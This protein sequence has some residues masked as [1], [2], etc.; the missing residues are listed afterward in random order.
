[1]VTVAEVAHVN[2]QRVVEHRAV[3]FL[4]GVQFLR[5][6]G[7]PLGMERSN[8]SQQFIGC[9]AIFPATVT[10]G[11]GAKRHAETVPL[12]VAVP[13]TGRDRDHI[14]QARQQRTGGH[15][16]L[17][18]ETV[19]L[20]RAL[21]LVGI[22]HVRLQ[23]VLHADDAVVTIEH[24]FVRFEVSVEAL[25]LRS[26]QLRLDS[27]NIPAHVIH[28]LL[29]QEGSLGG[30]SPGG[31]A[32]QRLEG[33][34]R[35]AKQ[36]KRLSFGRDRTGVTDD[37]LG[38]G[39]QSQTQMRYNTRQFG[40]Q[41]RVDGLLDRSRRAAVATQRSKLRR[42][43]APRCDLVRKPLDDRHAVLEGSQRR[44][45]IGQFVFRQGLVDKFVAPVIC[46][47]RAIQSH[48]LDVRGGHAVAFEEKDNP[49]WGGFAVGLG[50]Q[51]LQHRLQ[52]YRSCSE[53]DALEKRSTM[54]VHV[55]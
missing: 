44:D 53:G 10:D 39:S 18:F 29:S 17:R 2:D 21:E 11:V 50:V 5:Q 52:H 34:F 41:R 6:G 13:R 28:Q 4:D 7:D 14:R 25:S 3:A 31:T 46:T 19:G 43:T 40:R 54:R 8:N 30:L 45:R 51:L 26:G 47:L 23:C 1:M 20:F 37:R 49:P 48:R 22:R 55:H 9:L 24:R 32:E 42:V 16:A 15:V 27:L 35:L 38:A 36:R 33:E 12:H